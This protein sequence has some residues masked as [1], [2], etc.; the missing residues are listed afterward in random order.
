MLYPQA[1]VR[2]ISC[3]TLSRYARWIVSAH[4]QQA[5]ASIQQFLPQFVDLVRLWA[6][7]TFNF[8]VSCRAGSVYIFKY[9]S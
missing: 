3:W 2:S 1:L 6:D 7:V 5:D 9:R 8:R 4:K